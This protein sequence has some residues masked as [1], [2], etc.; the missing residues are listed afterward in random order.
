[1]I[2]NEL[3]IT[4]FRGF[5]DVKFPLG[6]AVTLI[7]GQNGTQKTTVLGMLSQAFTIGKS[8][9]L[10]GELPL[11]G[12]T[13]RS[14]FSDKFRFSDEFDKP[15]EHEWTLKL[16]IQEEPF[17]VESIPRD[18]ATGSI[19]FW[20]KGKR[21]EGDGYIQL[22]VIYLSLKRL[23]PIGEDKKLTQDNSI[24]L[25]NEEVKF[26]H[27]SYNE[28]LISNEP[29]TSIEA[30]ESR[31]KNTA[32]VS[33]S[34]Y[35]WKTNSAGQ[36]NIGKILL[37]V[38]SFKRL[39]NNYPDDYKGGIIA[40]DEIDATL[41]P[42]S[43]IKLLNK[44][45]KFSNDYGIQFIATTHSLTLIEELDKIS[46]QPGRSS[47]AVS[48]FLS[49]QNQQIVADVNLKYGAIKN[50]LNVSMGNRVNLKISVYTE[51]SETI[52]FAKAILGTK[53]KHLDFKR[54]TL[55]CTQYFDLI[56]HSVDEFLFPKSI[57]ILDA[58]VIRLSSYQKYVRKQIKKNVVLLPGD[59]NPESTLAKFLIQLD[60]TDDLW[61]P[62]SEDNTYTKQ[63]C[64]RDYSI[65]DILSDRKKAKD[66]YNQQKGYGNWGRQG[67]KLIRKY[68]EKN[69]EVKAKFLLDF[70]KIYSQIA[71]ERGLKI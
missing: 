19:R 40:I 26:F 27:Q 12:G 10:H 7:S 68:L 31:Q 17:I 6:K 58:D 39:K 25:S 55:G 11:C 9:P 60:D 66:W 18:Q 3:E 4:K 23:F 57:I 43:Q 64:F 42:G 14:M 5:K 35:D 56:N 16:S 38:L 28:I 69:P 67:V 29:I 21:Q 54:S 22:P 70:E 51:D 62:R 1:M 59:D 71:E 15:K 61:A 24:T 8:S 52:D 41:Y 20:Q 34:K 47:Q 30:L 46:R 65:D 44:L 63:I 49:K 48:V 33:T 45:F 50:N 36:D 37:A 13:Y 2:I 53:Y 32:G